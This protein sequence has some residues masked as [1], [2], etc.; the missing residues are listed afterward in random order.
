[1]AALVSIFTLC[2]T[3]ASQSYPSAKAL[4]GDWQC[5]GR[6]D[7]AKE[8]AKIDI[9]LG[10]ALL[11][12]SAPNKP[13]K[14]EAYNSGTGAI[15]CLWADPSPAQ[16]E[17]AKALNQPPPPSTQCVERAIVSHDG[18]TIVWPQKGDL[19]G[20]PTNNGTAWVPEKSVGLFDRLRSPFW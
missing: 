17:A 11:F 5:V 4:A 16:L 8:P 12:S 6:A 9:K 19:K 15:E 13:I 10:N 2:Y 20:D 3:V 18:R 14:T 7:C 1:M